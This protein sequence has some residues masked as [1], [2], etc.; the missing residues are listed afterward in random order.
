MA[1]P[2][3]DVGSICCAN[4]VLMCDSDKDSGSCKRF[5]K[6][7]YIGCPKLSWSRRLDFKSMSIQDQD[8]Q[9]RKVCHAWTEF[10]LCVICHLTPSD[11]EQVVKL[12]DHLEFHLFPILVQ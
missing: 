1:D 2:Y 7:R 3:S 12:G 9:W 4:C 5:L 10:V 11:I 6:R 8:V